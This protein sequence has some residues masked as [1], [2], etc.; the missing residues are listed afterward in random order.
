MTNM[1]MEVDILERIRDLEGQIA[2]QQ[3]CLDILKLKSH[4]TISLGHHP[5]SATSS[6]ATGS[7]NTAN[8]STSTSGP[9]LRHHFDTTATRIAH[10]DFTS[11]VTT[12]VRRIEN[13]SSGSLMT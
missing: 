10:S 1:D 6:S 13:G 3:V 8:L 7:P 4:D 12:G 5:L 9:G 2:A 11:V